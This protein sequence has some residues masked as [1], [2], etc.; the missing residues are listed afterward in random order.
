MARRK[1]SSVRLSQACE[2]LLGEIATNQ[3]AVIRALTLIGADAVGLDLTPVEADL[4]AALS[5]DLPEVV[6]LRLHQIVQQVR[7]GRR[8]ELSQEQNI[9]LASHASLACVAAERDA[10]DPQH[11]TAP[12]QGADGDPLS[13]VG[14]DF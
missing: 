3:S 8:A 13:S 12:H 11:E 1:P 10:G 5:A 6:Y 7:S 2:A 9:S 4:R 14:F